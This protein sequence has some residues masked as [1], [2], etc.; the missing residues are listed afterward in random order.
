[1]YCRY[2][3]SVLICLCV[4]S[5]TGKVMA[6]VVI[7]GTR[8]VFSSEEK[9]V[10]VKLNNEGKV[11]SLV[12]VW[13]D[14]GNRDDAPGDVKVP[15][16]L[17]PPLFRLDP[18]KG[19]TLRMLYTKEPLPAD[20]E[21]LFWLNVLEIPPKSPADK[22]AD[23]NLIQMA[24]RSR[25]KVFYRPALFNTHARLAGAYASIVWK[26]L[27]SPGGDGYLVEARNPSPYYITVTHVDVSSSA[28]HDTTDH[29]GMIAPFE[30]LQFVIG[31]KNS[32]PAGPMAL[33]FSVL[34]D[35]GSEVSIVSAIS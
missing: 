27:P 24:F 29:G 8:V 23:S 3:L 16:V 4:L 32:L 7:S 2:L 33:T 1:M 5:W 19:Q 11:P 13:L 17:T 31:T 20:R 30:T 15:F 28:R 35:Y 34:N 21:S 10:T 26:V 25:I 12:Q 22:D 18:N 9:E 14:K 6:S